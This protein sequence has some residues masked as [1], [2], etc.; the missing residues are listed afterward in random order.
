MIVAE[1]AARLGLKVDKGAWDEGTKRISAMKVAIAGG[2][3]LAVGFAINKFKDL[4]KEAIDYGSNLDDATHKTGVSS[5]F[6][7]ELS[8]AAGG[9]TD[10]LSEVS[11]AATKFGIQLQGAIE[12]PAGP[13]AKALKE[14]GISLDDPR[15]KMRDVEGLLGTV[16][17]RF[18]GMADGAEKNAIAVALMGKSGA[19][20][21]QALTE[22]AEKR[23]EFDEVGGALS[24][25]QRK[26]L[27]DVGDSLGKLSRDWEIL[28][29]RAIAAIAPTIK[30]MVDRA[31]E[32]LVKNQEVIKKVIGQVVTALTRA[33]EWLV[34]KFGQVSEWVTAHRDDI[35]KAFDGAVVAVLLLGRVLNNI[36][37]RLTIVGRWLGEFAAKTVIW[38]QGVIEWASAAYVA[39][40]EFLA[41]VGEVGEGVGEFFVGVGESV[42]AVWEQIIGWIED[43]VNWIAGKA[44]WIANKLGLTD[45]GS[46]IQKI[47]TGGIPTA[48]PS[49]VDAFTRAF[50]VTSAPAA[51]AAS[52]S[53]VT[54]N[55]APVNISVTPT[56]GMNAVDLAKLVAQK[57]KEVMDA[58]LR[59]AHE[60][61]VTVGG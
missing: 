48:T 59:V 12:N 10:K 20:L 56:P 60:T 27:D 1:L 54:V 37:G 24:T 3:S 42:K 14:L 29:V 57:T 16:S 22:L 30:T 26:G 34:E 47:A 43:K 46:S 44:E 31:T 13:A 41:K 35:A 15:V 49:P 7:E 9:V 40:A 17:E 5:Q 53:N 61:L 39:V 52:N 50:S 6:L 25:N 36:I 51:A 55:G 2:L 38:F 33:F 32:F 58:Q 8:F 19:N 23:K 28:K 4:A 11:A 21:S 45:V 18:A